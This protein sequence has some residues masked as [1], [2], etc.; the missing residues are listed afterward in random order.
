MEHVLLEYFSKFFVGA[1]PPRIS[2]AAGI[3]REK[4][5]VWRVLAERFFLL[6]PAIMWRSDYFLLMTFVTCENG[7]KGD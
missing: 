4:R 1:P 5:G 7:E 6:V 3:L 2:G